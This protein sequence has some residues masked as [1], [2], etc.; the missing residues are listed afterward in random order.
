MRMNE[1]Q[2]L[3]MLRL[4][5]YFR[6]IGENTVYKVGH[7]ITGTCGYIACSNQTTK[8]VIRVYFDTNVVEVGEPDVSS[9]N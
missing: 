1:I 8:K 6:F 4:G 5:S 3:G 9:N 7:Y 2:T